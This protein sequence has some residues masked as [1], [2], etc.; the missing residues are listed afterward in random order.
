[1]LLTNQANRNLFAIAVGDGSAEDS[2]AQENSF[3][4]VTQ[5]SMPEVREECFGFVVPGVDR[6]VVLRLAA[7]FPYA[8]LGVLKW[9]GH[10]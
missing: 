7:E 2:F 3:G 4:V 5:R 1:M 6:E 9:M 8:S 10:R